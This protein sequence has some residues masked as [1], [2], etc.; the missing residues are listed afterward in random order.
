[1]AATPEKPRHRHGIAVVRPRPTVAMDLQPIAEDID[2]RELAAIEDI[3]TPL[4][5]GEGEPQQHGDARREGERM[6]GEIVGMHKGRIGEDRL[7]AFGR[8]LLR[9]E[10]D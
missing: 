7:Y 5:L 4:A 8:T 2:P 3:G 1:M 10:I 9:Q 6:P